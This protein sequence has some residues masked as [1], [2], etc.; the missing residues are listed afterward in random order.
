MKSIHC[1]CGANVD[2]D[3]FRAAVGDRY[4]RELREH[5][6]MTATVCLDKIKKRL[7]DPAA[8]A[9]QILG[10]DGEVGRYRIPLHQSS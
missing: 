1:A 4:G 6:E 8:V 10:R 2:L 3:T 7:Q 5:A 9:N